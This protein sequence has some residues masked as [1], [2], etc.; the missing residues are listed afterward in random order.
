MEYTE[1]ELNK[2]IAELEGYKPVIIADMV[3]TNDSFNYAPI[4]HSSNKGTNNYNKNKAKLY[5]LMVK[6]KVEIDYLDCECSIWREDLIEAKAT[7]RFK[8][9]SEIPRAIIMCILKSENII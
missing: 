4:E 3:K 2:M 1:L 9:E 6:Y 5:D 7:T 8:Q